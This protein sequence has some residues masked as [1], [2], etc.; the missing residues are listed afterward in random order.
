MNVCN[1]TFC[2]GW[3]C[4]DVKAQSEGAARTAQ[5]KT[6]AQAAIASWSE[7][8]D[9]QKQL[10]R[11]LAKA[12]YDLVLLRLDEK[13]VSIL[14]LIYGVH[15]TLNQALPGVISCS[16]CKKI[17]QLH[18]ASK[19]DAREK[20]S[21]SQYQAITSRCKD[22]CEETEYQCGSCSGKPRE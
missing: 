9:Q 19:A 14:H 13:H 6:A 18:V 20:Q 17:E 3:W 16:S 21:W 11:T 8:Q 1:F 12:E 22:T 10:S 7:S 2:I 5:Q 15:S 4:R